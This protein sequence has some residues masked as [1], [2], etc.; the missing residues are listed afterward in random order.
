MNLNHPNFSN[1]KPDLKIK[2]CGMRDAQNIEQVSQLGIDMMGFIFYE[3]SPRDVGSKEVINFEIL[4]DLSQ[5]NIKK[6]GVF[7]NAQIPE[8]LEK[9]GEYQ[10][11]Y[12]QLHG[13]E[14]PE[15][16]KNLKSVWPTIKII[17]A[18]S[19][20]E[21]FEFDKTKDFD[22]VCD[23]FVFDTKGKNRGG[24]GV[25]FDWKLLEKYNGSTPFLLSGGIGLDHAEAI[26]KLFFSRMIGVDLNSKFEIKPALKEVKK[27]EEFISKIKQQ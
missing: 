8:I 24:N 15:Y 3:K 18:F 12:V 20:G 4:N 5:K 27:L 2:V 16:C 23:L 25:T 22:E 13:D 19:I 10:L 6:V 26:S 14:S 21:D 17:K 11:D 7:V 1:R 9:V